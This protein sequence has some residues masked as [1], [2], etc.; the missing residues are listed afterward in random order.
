MPGVAAE[1]LVFLDESFA[2]TAMARLH[3]RCPRG[4]RLV[5]SAPAGHWHT[6]TLLSAVRLGGVC[7]PL[8]LDGTVTAEVF[9]GYCREVL[10]P[11]L[12]AGDVVV[13][14]NLSAHKDARVREAVEAA[15]ATLLYLPPYSPDLNPIENAWSKI[16]ASLRRAKARTL[17]ALV[18]AYAAALR[19]ITAE[20][21]RG[22]FRH[23]G[24]HATPR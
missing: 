2:N 16:K 18:D 17:D 23:C 14:D 15:G 12:G 19:S 11:A 3:G 24:Y 21:C 8:L 22:F 7:A 13:M 4:R 1:R 6:N 20:D 9:V 5:A 10:A